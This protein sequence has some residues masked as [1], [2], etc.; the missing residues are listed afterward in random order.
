MKSK[1]EIA[2]YAKKYYAD[3]KT[4]LLEYK[5]NYRIINKEKIADYNRKRLYG[6]TTEEFQDLMVK[7]L[8]C[9]AIC[10]L[11]KKLYVDHCH[12]T[13]QIRGLLCHHC[14]LTIGFGENSDNLQKAIDYLKKHKI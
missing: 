2:A 6:L 13:G 9:C 4:E 8:S 11:K 5:K 1:E 3:N 7:Q 14:N 10:G 12:E